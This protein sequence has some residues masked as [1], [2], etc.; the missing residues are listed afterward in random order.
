MDDFADRLIDRE[1]F[2]YSNSRYL[3]EIGKLKDELQTA[4]GKPEAVL[5]ITAAD[6]GLSGNKKGQTF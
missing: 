5:L 6:K 2:S 1:T 4:T 3:S